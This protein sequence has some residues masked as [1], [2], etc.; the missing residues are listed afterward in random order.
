[1]I[2]GRAEDLLVGPAGK[3]LI[4]GDRR[5]DKHAAVIATHDLPVAFVD[6][7]VMA[8]GRTRFERSVGPP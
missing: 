2:E 7:P 1:M 3:L 5:D 4:F 8:I 6:H